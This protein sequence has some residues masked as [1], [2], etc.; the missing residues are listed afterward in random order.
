MT[1]GNVLIRFNV[2]T[3]TIPF[4]EPK[5]HVEPLLDLR[6]R[7]IEYWLRCDAGVHLGGFQSHAEAVL[8]ARGAG[9]HLV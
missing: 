7:V 3:G 6:G 1:E 5:Y 2:L 8:A 4:V 9:M